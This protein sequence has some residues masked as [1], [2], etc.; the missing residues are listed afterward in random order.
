MKEKWVGYYTAK[1]KHYGTTTTNRVEGIHAD[2][3]RALLST[4]TKLALTFEQI[5]KYYKQKV[6]LTLDENDVIVIC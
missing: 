5:D 2:V 4:T 1:V 6:L 3:K